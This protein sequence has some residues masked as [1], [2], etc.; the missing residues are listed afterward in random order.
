MLAENSH[1]AWSAVLRLT[2]CKRT[3]ARWPKRAGER[4]RPDKLWQVGLKLEGGFITGII[5]RYLHYILSIPCP[6]A[7]V[8]FTSYRFIMVSPQFCRVPKYTE[9]TSVL[10]G[11]LICLDGSH[12]RRIFIPRQQWILAIL[13]LRLFNIR[14]AHQ[15]LLVSQDLCQLPCDSLVDLLHDL[16]VGWEENIEVALMDLFFH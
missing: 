4:Y 8:P 1:R 15:E 11:S 3:A 14:P 12:D 2:W 13:T 5:L 16:E 7:H 6:V 10:S 9:E